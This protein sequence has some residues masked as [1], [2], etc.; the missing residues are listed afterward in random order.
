MARSDIST[1][2]A[3]SFTID[4]E[5][6]YPMID[7]FD[8]YK[9]PTNK[10]VLGLVRKKNKKKTYDKSIHEVSTIIWKHWTER[11]I[12]PISLTSI[13]KKMHKEV[14]DYKYLKHKVQKNTTKVWREK[15]E[16]FLQRKDK[17]FDIFCEDKVVR[18]KHEKKNMIPMLDQDF[19]Y[20]ESM[21][22]DRKGI[23]ELKT[24]KEWHEKEKKKKEKHEHYLQTQS[25]NIF[26]T[27]SVESDETFSDD[28]SNVQYRPEDDD[29]DNSP[30]KREKVINAPAKKKS[31]YI[32]IPK[33]EDDMLPYH[34]TPY[35]KLIR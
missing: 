21:R 32:N 25:G 9:L 12:Y 8:K 34:L 22:T 30:R 27:V 7:N 18:E 2:S 35:G 10:E 5:R 17:L 14:D 11:N 4:L 33:N 19:S 31:K 16:D 29:S 3:G 26:T 20:L 28:E 15:A 1:R 24:D 13:K 6:E 23:C